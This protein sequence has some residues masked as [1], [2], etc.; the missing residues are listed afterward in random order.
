MVISISMRVAGFENSPST[1]ASA[2]IFFNTG[3]QVVEV[4]FPVCPAVRK[5]RHS[6]AG[7]DG[8]TRR[9]QANLVIKLLDFSPID[10][11]TYDLFRATSL[12]FCNQ[13]LLAH[14][15]VLV[16]IHQ[17]AQSHFKR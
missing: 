8:Q 9:W 11:Q 5:D 1:V 4:A 6:H 7:S 17:P 15:A 13:R 16:E 2:I 12:F 14:E 10:L 3:D